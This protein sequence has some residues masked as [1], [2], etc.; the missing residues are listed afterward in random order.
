MAESGTLRD[1]ASS[2]RRVR[3]AMTEA[4]ISEKS[5]S[6]TEISVITAALVFILKKC[7]HLMN[8]ERAS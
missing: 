2:E 6:G 1:L 3:T 7:A 8:N 5:S 4:S